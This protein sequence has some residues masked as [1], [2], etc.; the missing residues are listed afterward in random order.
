MAKQPGN[1]NVPP[2][3][4]PGPSDTLGNMVK[5]HAAAGTFL[6]IAPG[7]TNP[8]MAA[9]GMAAGAGIG[10]ATG[11]IRY[12]VQSAKRIHSQDKLGAFYEER[13]NRNL[14][15]QFPK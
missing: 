12:G 1:P 13:R 8:L 3:L 4:H 10:A 2:K 5:E 11:A 7:F 14:G 15:R 6:G 9:A